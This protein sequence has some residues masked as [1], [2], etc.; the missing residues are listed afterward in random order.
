MASELLVTVPD[1]EAP[2][3]LY[4]TASDH[5]VSEVLVRE[6]EEE[7]KVIQCLLYLRST[8]RSKAKLYINQKDSLRGVDFI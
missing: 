8:F 5:T 1:L 6:K 4:I 3:L 2:L 7:S